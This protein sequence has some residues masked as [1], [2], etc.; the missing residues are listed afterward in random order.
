[1]DKVDGIVVHQ[2]ASP[3][4]SSTFSSYQQADANGA[5]FLIDRDGTIYQTASVFRV[6]WHVG[7][8]QS[9]CLITKKCAPAEF[10]K[11]FAMERASNHAKKVNAAERKKDFPDRYPNN[12]DSIGI[13]IVGETLKEEGKKILI[14][15]SVN[16][17]QNESLKWL[18][19]ELTDTLKVSMNEI[20]RHPQVGRKNDTEAS[21]AKW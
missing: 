18:L 13:E 16:D 11:M 12:S 7:Y 4:A 9:R 3:S 15:E 17:Q 6:T 10:K 14:F 1:M 20:Y 5:H 8:L 2:T 19:R 21:T